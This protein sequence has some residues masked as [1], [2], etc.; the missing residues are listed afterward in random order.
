[1]RDRARADGQQRRARLP[2][3]VFAKPPVPGQVK[4]RL[5]A[6]LGPE[7]AAALARAFLLDAWGAV[8]AC[9][10]A[11]P[12]LASTGPLP[13]EL[14]AQLGPGRILLQGEGDL[15]ARLERVLGGLLARG[16]PAALALGADSPGLP[17]RLLE[18]AR[19]ALGGGAGAVLG[20]AADGGFYLLGLGRCPP[21]LL[22]GLPWSNART[23]A[24]TARRLRAQGLVVVEIEPWFDVDRPADLVRLGAAL[25]R[26]EIEAPATLRALARLQGTTVPGATGDGKGGAE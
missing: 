15:G 11:E 10:W 17:R 22:A 26:G 6:A 25:Q 3:V 1:M 8:A 5:V 2:V 13:A 4:T 7:G 21:G 12:Y 23:R 9:P 24:A 18:Q 16:A 14:V 20:P 19:A